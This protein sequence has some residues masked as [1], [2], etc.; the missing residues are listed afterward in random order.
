L[1][2]EQTNSKNFSGE[3]KQPLSKEEKQV[4]QLRKKVEILHREDA[5]DAGLLIEA[6]EEDTSPLSKASKIP[7]DRKARFR[8]VFHVSCRLFNISHNSILLTG[9]HHGPF[10]GNWSP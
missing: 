9:G 6:E 7:V 10:L 5:R 1:S 8:F 3:N 4:F 2:S